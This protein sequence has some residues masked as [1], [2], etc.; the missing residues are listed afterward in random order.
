MLE[1]GEST[2]GGHVDV[3]HLAATPVGE[4]VT[5]LARVVNV[6]GPAISFQLEAHDQ[7]ELIARGFQGS[8]V[9]QIDRFAQ[10]V[11]RKR[12]AQ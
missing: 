8:R 3:R 5:C 9:I 10:K 7:H 1:P 11:N 2:V 6:K 12:S 4:T